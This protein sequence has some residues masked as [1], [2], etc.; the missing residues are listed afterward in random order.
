VNGMVKRLVSLVATATVLLLFLSACSGGVAAGDSTVKVAGVAGGP[1]ARVFNPLLTDVQASSGATTNAIFEPLLMEDADHADS[2]PWLAKSFQWSPDGKTLTLHIRDGVKWSDGEPLTAEDVAF[3][4]ELIRRFPALN[5]RG[6]SLAG[7]T[8]Q[9]PTTAVISFSV[10]SAQLFWWREKT[11][12]KHLWKDVS[13]PV[14]FANENPVGTGPYMLKTFTPHVITLVRNPNYWK[15]QPKINTLQFISFDSTSSMV[16]AFQA[17]EVDWINPSSTT[18]DTIARRDPQHI[19]YLVARPGPGIV[20]LIPNSS[21]YPLDQPVVRRALSAAVDREKITKVALKGMN[22]PALSPT[23]I[24]PA[25][26]GKLLAPEY[27]HLRYGAGDPN[28]AASLLSGA[29]YQRGA[30]GIFVSPKGKRLKLDLVVPSSYAY[31]DL[32]QASRL[33][34]EQL[35]AAGIEIMVKSLQTKP[36]QDAANLGQFDLTMRPLGNTSSKYDNFQRML[37]QDG[38]QPEG[39]AAK[40]NPGRYKNP[41]AGQLLVRYAGS[42]P[43]SRAEKDA[44]AGLQR[45]MV[46]DV[47]V[48]PMFHQSALGMWRTSKVTGWPSESDRYAVP[49]PND[50]TEPLVLTRLEPVA[51]AR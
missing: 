40:L 3:T 47:P 25:T 30:D 5:A 9:G 15:T 36:W 22:D 14:K 1:F 32:L 42:V 24:D 41:E 29:G 21:R 50:V 33:I 39:K 12:P 31:A 2:Q 10:P 37:S 48:V 13:D 43:G 8:A 27:K 20:Y 34:T 44:L 19:K 49:I 38:L 28:A 17:G 11:L 16:A 23:G 18:P 46:D 6:F 35:R 4:W 7:A 26:E 45:L 51:G